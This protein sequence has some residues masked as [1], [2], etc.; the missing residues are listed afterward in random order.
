MTSPQV[1]DQMAFLTRGIRTVIP[2]RSAL[3]VSTPITSGRLLIQLIGEGL[4]SKHVNWER[5]HSERVVQ[6]NIQRAAEI[7][8]RIRAIQTNLCVIDPTALEDIEGWQQVDYRLFWTN[9]IREFTSAVAF[10]DGWEFS[11]GCCHEMVA[12]L[13]VSSRVLNEE[14]E[15]LTPQQIIAIVE[16]AKG[17]ASLPPALDRIQE[18]IIAT[19]ATSVSDR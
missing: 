13:S 9:V 15:V 7:V 5:I 12:A 19:L 18:E 6:P 11:E 1:Q 8:A 14:L 3:Y 2:D 10:V 17:V 4:E 16:A